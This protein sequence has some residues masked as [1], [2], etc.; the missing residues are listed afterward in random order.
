ML[1]TM[2][3]LLA[4]ASTQFTT[5]QPSHLVLDGSAN[6]GRWRCQTST[7]EAQMSV[8]ADLEEINAVIDRAGEAAVV[9]VEG[10]PIPRFHLRV[11]ISAVRCVNRLME[12]EMFRALRG[13]AHPAI[14]FRLREVQ[15]AIRRE[16]EGRFVASVK[17]DLMVAGVTR[18]IVLELS[19]W[20]LS[21]ESY[22]FRAAIPLRMR[23][24]DVTPPTSLFGIIRSRN[25]INVYFDLRLTTVTGKSS[26]LLPPEI[27]HAP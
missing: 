12:K 24:F 22:Y 23:D 20:R 8:E 19:A 6:I 21:P 27:M 17:G 13:A 2:I 9:P 18:S 7:L 26:A 10:V 3:I 4:S 14:E 5:L 1:S 25:E 11:P 16:T 15:G